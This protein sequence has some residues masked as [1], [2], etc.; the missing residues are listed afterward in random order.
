M[1][2]FV[3]SFGDINAKEYGISSNKRRWH[4]LKFE[5]MRC[6]AYYRAALIRGRHLFQSSGNERY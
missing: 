4:L 2:Y 5:T 3:K 1:L 6:G